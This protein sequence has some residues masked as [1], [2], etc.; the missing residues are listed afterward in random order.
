MMFK[1]LFIHSPIRYI[2][3]L[4]IMVT[5]VVLYRIIQRDF[6]ISTYSKLVYY[7]NAFFL[8][9]LIVL[10]TGLF[11]LVDIFGGFNIFRYMFVR[12]N[13]NGTKK[14]LQDYNLEREEK[15]KFKHFIYIPYLVVATIGLIISVLLLIISSSI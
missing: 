8:A 2:V 3:S 12:K 7:S 13:V 1:K 4:G 15:T 6:F 9:G 14:T 10:C 11:V 5:F